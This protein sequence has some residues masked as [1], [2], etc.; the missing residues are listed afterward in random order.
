MV[1]FEILSSSKDVKF[2]FMEYS[3]MLL[4]FLKYELTSK[5]KKI[6][7]KIQSNSE[8]FKFIFREYSNMLSLLHE[9]ELTFK[10]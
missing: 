8:G 5:K 2:M 4:M 9:Y 7:Y 1:V 6:V 10:K 3:N